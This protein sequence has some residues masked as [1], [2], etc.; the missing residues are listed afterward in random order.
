MAQRR[1]RILQHVRR[2]RRTHHRDGA[3]VT[4]L[5]LLGQELG[6]G[7]HDGAGGEHVADAL[8]EFVLGAAVGDRVRG[9]VEEEEVAFL[10]AEDTF[11]DEAL[12]E[13]FADLFELVA[14][15][16]EV[17]GFACERVSGAVLDG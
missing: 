9:H 17:P 11:V 13:A 3:Q 5:D 14:D 6:G 1:E 4:E 8:A 16:H 12:L 15:L 7:Q 10:G 2:I